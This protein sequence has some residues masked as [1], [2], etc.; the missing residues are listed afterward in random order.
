MDQLLGELKAT[1]D[2]IILDSPPFVVS[3]AS[4]LAARVD[5]VLIVVY[6]GHTYSGAASSMLE[7]LNRSGARVLGVVMNRIPHNRQE[8]YGNY[9]HYSP[10]NYR[11]KPGYKAYFKEVDPDPSRRARKGLPA[12]FHRLTKGLVSSPAASRQPID[13][14]S[15][16]DLPK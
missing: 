9:R 2:I 3:D 8:Y 16:A 14:A 4:L 1:A 11:Y 13:P 7:Q 12:L 15:H 5:G 6:P 10:Y